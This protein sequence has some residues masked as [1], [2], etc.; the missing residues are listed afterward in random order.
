MCLMR[1]ETL[2]KEDQLITKTIKQSVD[3]LVKVLDELA[4][5]IVAYEDYRVY[6]WEAEKHKWAALH[7][8]KVI[9]AIVTVCQLRGL[10]CHG[11]MAHAVKTFVT[12]EKLK[13]WDLY[14]KGKRHARDAT[15][16][17]IYQMIFGSKGIDN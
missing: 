2:L 10:E 17:A 7:T 14:T 5:D 9:G 15:R 11:R 6:A 12:D 13:S 4:P 1:G 16:H 3:A 8:P